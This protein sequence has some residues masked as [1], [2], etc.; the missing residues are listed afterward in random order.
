MINVNIISAL[1]SPFFQ[2][3]NVLLDFLMLSNKNHR[4]SEGKERRGEREASC[5]APSHIFLSKVAVSKLGVVPF[6]NLSDFTCTFFL[7]KMKSKS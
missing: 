1:N 3:K 5:L 2:T 6:K 7:P 4:G